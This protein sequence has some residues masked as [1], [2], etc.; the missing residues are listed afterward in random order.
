MS[1]WDL[2]GNSSKTNISITLLYIQDSRKKSMAVG[3]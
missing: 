3:S 2:V 1:T